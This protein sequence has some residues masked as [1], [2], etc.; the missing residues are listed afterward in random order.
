MA[1]NFRVTALWVIIILHIGAC[2][3]T[4]KP[5]SVSVAFK[6]NNTTSFSKKDTMLTSGSSS[7][8][9]FLPSENLLKHKLKTPLIAAGKNQP[10][11]S[12]KLVGTI[13]DVK[14]PMAL[15][16]GNMGH[17]YVVQVGSN[18]GKEKARVISI[19]N[20]IVTLRVKKLLANKK[21]WDLK[22]LSMGK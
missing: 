16:E 19:D 6:H 10:L 18:V 2:S 9:P 11:D 22:V 7:R 5:E 1:L 14:T 17:G 4:S 3:D 8:N 15:L 20:G 21:S 13:T 12:Y